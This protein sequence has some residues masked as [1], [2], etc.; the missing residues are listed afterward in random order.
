MYKEIITKGVL[1][2]AMLVVALGSLAASIIFFSS[3][4]VV[5][6]PF[7]IIATLTSIG[8]TIVGPNESKVLTLFGKYVGTIKQN[9]FF[10]V[11]PFYYR[12]AISLRARNLNGQTLKVNDK[13][14]N[15]ID[16]AAVVV[17]K[18]NDTAQAAFEVDDYQHYVI[19]QSEAAVRQLASAFP[20]DHFEDEHASITLRDGGEKLN[21]TLEKALNERLERAGIHVLESRISH[22][23][24]AT[25]SA[26]NGDRCGT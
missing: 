17:W 26:G 19:V 12:K 9:G 8:F 16:I 1:G 21:E 14:G 15:P 7:V 6:V 3:E 13:V 22:L 20:Y 4:S 23:A 18:V 24:Y 25:A 11:N 10:W 5:G 2:Y